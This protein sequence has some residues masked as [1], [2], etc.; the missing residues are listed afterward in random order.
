MFMKT[1]KDTRRELLMPFDGRLAFKARL[2]SQSDD[3]VRQ[4]VAASPG[5]PSPHA[6]QRNAGPGRLEDFSVSLWRLLIF[7]VIMPKSYHLL[8]TMV[9]KNNHLLF[10]YTYNGYLCWL[11]NH[12]MR[13]YKL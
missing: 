6:L 5:R 1:K 12:L 7:R 10:L 3:P 13:I 2:G 11:Y 9:K 4:A 8:I